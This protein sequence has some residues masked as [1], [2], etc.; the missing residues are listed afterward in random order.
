[1]PR[2]LR[3]SAAWED[4]GF[5]PHVGFQPLRD[6]PRFGLPTVPHTFTL[7]AGIKHFIGF[8]IIKLKRYN[9]P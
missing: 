2:N 7:I 6:Q 1:M 8:I 3:N 9:I 4:G 5:L